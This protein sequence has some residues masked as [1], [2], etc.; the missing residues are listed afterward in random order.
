MPITH[1]TMRRVDTRQLLTGK[2]CNVRGSTTLCDMTRLKSGLVV[3]D[4]TMLDRPDYCLVVSCRFPIGKSCNVQ[5]AHYT[6]FLL[7]VVSCRV[8]LYNVRW[9]LVKWP[10][11]TL[12]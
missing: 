4:L 5:G 3:S 11:Y 2:P 7:G 12:L 10:H 8:M 6:I 1:N 9:A